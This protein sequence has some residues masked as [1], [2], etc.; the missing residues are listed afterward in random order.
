ME[1]KE[2]KYLYGEHEDNIFI[3]IVGNATMKN[4]KTLEELL[5]QILEG[6][7]KQIILDFEECNYMDSTMLGLIAKTAIKIKKTWKMSIYGIKLS[8]MVKTS[9]NSTGVD[10]LMTILEKS[11]FEEYESRVLENKDFDDKTEKAEHILEAH[12]TLMDLSEENKKVFKNVV[13]LLE[14]ELNK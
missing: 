4:S 9:L 14:K 5:N 3:K 2:D 13:N 8:N 10:K 6:E 12:K 11:D 1:T 7:T